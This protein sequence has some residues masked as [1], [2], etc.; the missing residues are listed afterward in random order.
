VLQC[1]VSLVKLG[2]EG[3]HQ[4]RIGWEKGVRGGLEWSR[5]GIR[6]IRMGLEWGQSGIRMGLEW[7]QSGIRMG[8]EWD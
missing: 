7:G 3:L 4:S 6:G 1:S 8:S 5:V 2:A